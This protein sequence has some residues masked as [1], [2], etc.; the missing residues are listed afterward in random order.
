MNIATTCS[1]FRVNFS[2][3]TKNYLNKV[4]I[5]HLA[6]KF[7]SREKHIRRFCRRQEEAEE[8]TFMIHHMEEEEDTEGK[9]ERLIGSNSGQGVVRFNTDPDVNEKCL[10]L[11]K[12]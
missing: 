4:K 1:F 12:N 2:K 7:D 5:S 11:A 8:L 3:D 10:L 6:D 9:S